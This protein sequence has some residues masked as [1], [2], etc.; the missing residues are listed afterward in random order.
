[1]GNHEYYSGAELHRYLDSTWEQYGPI[2]GG[3]VS[4][5]DDEIAVPGGASGASSTGNGGGGGHS[6]HGVST[7]TSGLGALLS[8]G[9]HHSVGLHGSTPS[10]SSRYFSLDL[11]LIHLVAIDLNFY[12][13]VD[14]CTDG[15]CQAAQKEWLARDLAAAN[16]NRDNVP[17]VLVMSHYP[18]FW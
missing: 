9:L 17:W 4:L 11:G 14:P 12:Y 18:F 13:G 1:V 6:Y 2:A 3:N 10:N 15:S 8:R 16:R 7:A 5:P